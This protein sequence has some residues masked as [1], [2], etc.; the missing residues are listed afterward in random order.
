[1]PEQ[2]VRYRCLISG[3]VQMVGFRY[4]AA[5]GATP[6]GL[7]GWVRNLPDGRVEVL[8]QGSYGVVEEFIEL[9]RRGP[10]TAQVTGFQAKSEPVGGELG[11]F[12]PR[13]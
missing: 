13:V 3:R 1:M 11:P 10:S 9:L 4:F 12:R 7:Q 8:V 6:R 5:A 2:E